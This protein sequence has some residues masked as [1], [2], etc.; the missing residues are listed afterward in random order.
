VKLALVGGSFDP[1]HL[2]HL[3]LAATA[4]WVLEPD[5]L[6]LLPVYR[7]PFSKSLAPFADRLA[8]TRLACAP[9]GA[10]V[11]VSALEEELAAAGGK[12]T[13]I[14][15]L[16]HLHAEAPSRSLLWVMGADLAAETP[17]WEN[18]PEVERLSTVVWFNRQGHPALPGGGPPLPDVSATEVREIARSGGDLHALVP[19]AVARYIAERKLYGA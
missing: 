10:H 16:R 14:E 2:G 18:F 19:T 13:T 9:F 15:L 17:R 6:W 12:G 11:R 8:M 5:E 3:L 1:P 7:H 4:L